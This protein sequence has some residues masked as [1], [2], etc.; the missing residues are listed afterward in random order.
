MTTTQINTDKKKDRLTFR[1]MFLLPYGADPW[2]HYSILWLSVF[3]LLMIGSASMGLS[4]ANQIYLP[5][6]IA[7]QIIFLMGGYASMYFLAS[8][9][10]FDFMRSSSFASWAL[11]VGLLLILCL[12]FPAVN[13]AKAWIRVPISSVDVS[14]QPSE[15][16]KIMIILIIA[17]Y[18]GD[19]KRR[20]KKDSDMWKRPL[21]FVCSY[22]F[23]VFVLQGD[24]GSMAVMLM[25]AFI[26]LEIPSH[27]QMRGIQR[28]GLIV[29]LIG[30][31]FAI[32]ILSPLGE[33]MIYHL[34]LQEYQINRFLSS[35]NPFIDQY[36][37]GYQ[38]INGLVAFATGGWFGLGYGNS[39]RKYTRFPAA[40]TD[41]ILAIIVEELGFVGFMAMFIPYCII[42]FRLIRYAQ[43]TNSEKAKI[44]LIGV[45]SYIAIHIFFNVGGVTGLIPLTGVPLL[46]I[47]AG[48]SS[49][50][51]T[52]VAIG[53]AQAVIA[54]IRTG[55]IG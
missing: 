40:N 41:F 39:V 1:K 23:I 4:V 6:T 31:V 24:F 37:T 9:F 19:V 51:A 53:I 20:F 52:L 5:F 47:S 22:L 27:P 15:F 25:I 14:I 18:T 48:G 43:K 26:C 50:L 45:A 10:N 46:M 35:V 2:I 54:R 36:D 29:F 17:A 3:G 21:I 32:Y 34:P 55:E 7:K 16:A 38:L 28:F 42:I 30:L 8:F 33:N 12:F 13:G 44:V 11:G 49:A